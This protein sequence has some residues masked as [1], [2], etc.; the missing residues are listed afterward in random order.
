MY[1]VFVVVMNRKISFKRSSTSLNG[2]RT[3]ANPSLNYGKVSRSLFLQQISG[4]IIK[5][6]T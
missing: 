3:V 2:K 1:G 6:H 4:E 5:L